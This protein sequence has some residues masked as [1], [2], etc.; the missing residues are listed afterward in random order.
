MTFYRWKLQVGQTLPAHCGTSPV[1][2]KTC[3]DHSED[4]S[5]NLVFKIDYLAYHPFDNVVEILINNH[6]YYHGKIKYLAKTLDG[7]DVKQ[8]NHPES[9]GFVRASNNVFMCQGMHCGIKNLHLWQK[10]YPW[11]WSINLSHL[12]WIVERCHSFRFSWNIH[13]WLNDWLV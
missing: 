8:S 4:V 10:K 13:Y 9:T 11:K 12:Q 6:T 1:Y 7:V 2:H 5:G 3:N